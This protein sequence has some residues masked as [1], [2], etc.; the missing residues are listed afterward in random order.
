MWCGGSSACTAV[1]VDTIETWNGATWTPVPT[2]SPPG[3]I[4][5]NLTAVSCGGPLSC[6]AGGNQVV[7]MGFPP[8]FVEEGL[9]MTWNGTTWT[10]VSGTNVITNGVSCTGPS[11]CVLATP[12]GP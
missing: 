7:A 11:S 3:A 6:F 8:N 1:G 5:T 4:F 2:P 9:D 12:G 10:L